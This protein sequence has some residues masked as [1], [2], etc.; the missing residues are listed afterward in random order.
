VKEALPNCSTVDLI[1]THLIS[2]NVGVASVDDL[3]E[4]TSENLQGLHL[5]PI[6]VKKLLRAFQSCGQRASSLENTNENNSKF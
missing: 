1:V 4:V 2:Q 3:S 6:P 5:A